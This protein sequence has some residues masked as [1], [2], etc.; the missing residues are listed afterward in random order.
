MRERK[1]KN[2]G[3]KENHYG[4]EARKEEKHNKQEIE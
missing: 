4:Q 1:S 2:V 3:Q